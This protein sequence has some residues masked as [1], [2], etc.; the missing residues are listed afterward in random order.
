[1][2]TRSPHR[3]TVVEFDEHRGL[4][5]VR[6]DAGAEL[7]FHCTSL[8]DGTRSVAVGTP[9]AF[10]VAAGH[11]GRVE[12]RSLVSLGPAASRARP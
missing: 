12:A 5:T 4:G 11:G 8:V 7:P 6:D 10:V 3:G 9:V 2:T 1:M